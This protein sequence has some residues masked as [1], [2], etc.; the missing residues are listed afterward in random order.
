[1]MIDLV[2]MKFDISLLKI[3]SF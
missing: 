2:A 3:D 1:M